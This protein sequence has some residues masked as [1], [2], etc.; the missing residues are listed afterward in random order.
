MQVTI[1]Y[2][3]PSSETSA[4]E[5]A[6]RVA[7]FDNGSQAIVVR[8][9]LKDA[10]APQHIV[11]ATVQAFG[12]Q[13][14]ILV[15]NAG[16]LFEKTV[17][18]ITPGDF[19]DIFS[20]NVRAPLLMIKAVVPRLRAPGRII[21]LSSA[22]ARSGFERLSLYCASKAALEGLTRSLATELGHQ[23]HTVNCVAPGP[24]DSTDMVGSVPPEVIEMQLKT[25]AVQHRLGTV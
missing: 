23:G 20:V 24:V 25:T 13:V 17:L 18:D 4:H 21:N 12:E 10:N 19:D 1:V 5:V 2:T 6:S 7:T 15:N 11:A 16:V 9:D 3:S 14:D 22:G 8:A